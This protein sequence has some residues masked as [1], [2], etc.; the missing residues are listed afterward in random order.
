MNAHKGRPIDYLRSIL[1]DVYFGEYRKRRALS[2][3]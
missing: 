3:T 1:C 2:I